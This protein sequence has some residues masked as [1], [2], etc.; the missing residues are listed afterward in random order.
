MRAFPRGHAAVSATSFVRRARRLAALA[1]A[2]LPALAAPVQAASVLPTVTPQ[3]GVPAGW[4]APP[5]SYGMQV[6]SNQKIT[7]TD[8]VVLYADVYVPTDPATGKPAAGPFPVI[9]TEAPYGK[10][11]AYVLGTLA[12]G[13]SVMLGEL[14]DADG[15]GSWLVKRGYIDVIV[16]VRGTGVSGGQH[17]LLGPRE[18][19]DSVTVINWAARLPNS[20]GKV[21]MISESYEALDQ[22]FAAQALGPNSP[23]KAIFPIFPGNDA[24]RELLDNDGMFDIESFGILGGQFIV[25]DE[26][27]IVACLTGSCAKGELIPRLLTNTANLFRPDG[28]FSMVLNTLGNGDDAYDGSFWHQAR[29]ARDA[30]ADVV[31]NGVAVYVV[32][33]MYDV[34]QAGDLLDYS[35]LQ[36]ASVGRPVGAPML[37]SQT[38]SSRYQEL[39][40]P[41]YHIP[42]AVT[43]QYDLQSNLQNIQIA[44]FDRWLKGVNNGI[45]ATTTPLHVLDQEFHVIETSH[46][47]LTEAPAQTFYLGAHSLTAAKPMTVQA[48]DRIVYTGFQNFCNQDL[49]QFIA[50]LP[51]FFLWWLK[52]NDQCATHVSPT[53]LLLAYES[54]PFAEETALAGQIGATLFAATSSTDIALQLHVDDVAPDGSAQEITGGSIEGTFRALDQ[55]NTWTTDSGE[56]L[57]PWHVLTRDSL[58]PVTPNQVTRYDIQVRPAFWMFEPGHR[59]RL[60]IGTGDL[61]HLIP[62]PWNLSK[63][64]GKYEI[65]RDAANPS[66]ITLPLAPATAFVR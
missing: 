31:A 1:A 11:N 45:D 14:A 66:R 38:V 29:T 40:G 54:Q 20:N 13:G 57:L 42:E 63:L 10:N 51:D 21:G 61:P 56:I 64:M 32:G 6:Q 62:P 53:P 26:D 16:D 50:G 34:F 60:R 2:L 19:Q 52:L 23:L 55:A 46:Y 33:G 15:W 8:G 18:Q 39:W 37:A 41:F 25:P 49:E 58:E 65:Q 24:Y 9:V 44:W 36:N 28:V 43:P 59:L 35:G 47:P 5:Q 27:L 17:S 4:T 22:I 7:M 48:S 30:L 3:F 12:A